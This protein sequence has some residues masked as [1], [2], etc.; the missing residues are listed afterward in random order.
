MASGKKVALYGCLGCGGLI[1]LVI[2][3]LVGGIGFLSYQGYQFGKD[4]GEAY[5]GIF[6]KYSENNLTFPFTPPGDGILNEE[7]TALVF[8][9]RASTSE[10]AR[11]KRDAMDQTGDAIGSNMESPGI[12]SKIEGVKKI[13]AIVH[14]AARLGADI[15]EENI[16]LLDEHKMSM[17]EY[18]WTMKTCLGTLY[19]AAQNRVDDAT[20]VWNEYLDKF[21]EGSKRMGDMNIDTGPD[22]FRSRDINRYEFIERLQ[23][24]PFV[25]ANFTIVKNHLAQ[26][27]PDQDTGILDFL[28]IKMNEMLREDSPEHDTSQ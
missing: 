9:I 16:R 11:Q 25:E 8:A 15:A 3:V 23:D 7:R 10:F 13:A 14:Q 6:D 19:Q 22:R 1:L 5:A 12:L 28:A 27:Y 4:I 26:L 21:D 18:R 24:V 20:S 17:N 2:L